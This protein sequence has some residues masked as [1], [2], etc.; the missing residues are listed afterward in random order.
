MITF[1][2]S[3]P[4]STRKASGTSFQTCISRI[5]SIS[6]T[7]DSSA[8]PAPGL[9]ISLARMGRLFLPRGSA[10]I[11]LPLRTLIEN[12][13][14]LSCDDKNLVQLKGQ[15][16]LEYWKPGVVSARFFGGL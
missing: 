16:R 14:F 7:V 13:N 11:L 3:Q 6:W 9:K 10:S 12:N 8:A 5:T 1:V 15:P 2:R 4:G